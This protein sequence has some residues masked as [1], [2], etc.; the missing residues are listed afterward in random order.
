[1]D[2]LLK[3]ERF[4]L[5]PYASSASSD[6]LHW[7]RTFDNF[8]GKVKDID[9]D[10]KLNL[11]INYI[12]PSVFEYVSE[13]KTYDE[14]INIL[15]ST[16]VKV[17]NEIY[18]RHKLSNRNQGSGESLDQYIQALKILSKDCNF[19]AVDSEQNKNDYIRDSFISGLNS[20]IIRQRL[21]EHKQLSLN[22][23][24]EIARTLD[25][26]REQAESYLV[27][28]VSLHATQLDVPTSQATSGTSR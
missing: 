12:A 7:K 26:A 22:E 13:C 10:E 21:L 6:W 19:K 15:N 25:L 1:M 27:P 17:T 4:A 28:S 24:F 11:L 2:K 20:S 5:D 16:Y 23:A 3:P 8:I 14:A 9:E 18:A